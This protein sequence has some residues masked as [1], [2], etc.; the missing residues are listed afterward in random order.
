MIVDKVW[1]Y[2]IM[3][4][5]MTKFGSLKV[6]NGGDTMMSSDAIYYSAKSMQD[7]YR[8]V[9]FSVFLYRFH[10]RFFIVKMHFR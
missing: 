3:R 2:W 9:P 1:T 6:D 7:H 5:V 10:N 4:Q 8:R